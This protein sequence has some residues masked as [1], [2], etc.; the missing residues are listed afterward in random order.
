MIYGLGVDITEIERVHKIRQKNEKFITKVLTDNE[1]EFYQN[2]T[3][4]RKDEFLTGRF[5]VK[6]SYSKALGTG[7]GKYVTFKDL[8]ILD[9]EWG[10][11]EFKK[12]P[13]SEKLNAH[14]SISHTDEL[15]MTEVILEKK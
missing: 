11:P 4:K 5:S 3:E 15:V 14:V 9:N 7:I 8:E 6:E 1:F 12:H 13:Y 2:L 10:K